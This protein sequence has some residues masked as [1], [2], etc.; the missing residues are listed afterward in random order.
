MLPVDTPA[1]K[2]KMQSLTAGFSTMVRKGT[3]VVGKTGRGGVSLLNDFKSF[4]S[5]GNVIDLAVGI[6]VG[7]AFSAVVTSLVSDMSM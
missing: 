5:R 3:Q 4:I 2:P 1:S 7:A 6:V